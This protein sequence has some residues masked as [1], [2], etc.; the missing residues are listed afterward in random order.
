MPII[1][2]KINILGRRLLFKGMNEYFEMGGGR[3]SKEESIKIFLG[4]NSFH[5]NK[6]Y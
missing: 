5:L 1:Q 4:P 2:R 3:E 6:N